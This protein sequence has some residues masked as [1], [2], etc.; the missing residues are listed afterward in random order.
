MRRQSKLRRFTFQIHLMSLML[1]VKPSEKL[2]K[3]DAYSEVG[4]GSRQK[5]VDDNQ[6]V[7]HMEVEENTEAVNHVI[8]L[9]KSDKTDVISLDVLTGT[10]GGQSMMDP[11][12]LT[13]DGINYQ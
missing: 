12:H 9:K 13:Q 8:S 5:D 4:Q 3:I 1:K 6:Q 11:I 10:E 7:W 2:R